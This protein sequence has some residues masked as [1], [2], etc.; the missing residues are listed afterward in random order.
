V[1]ALTSIG[2][3]VQQALLRESLA[4]HLEHG[5]NSERR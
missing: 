2:F 1:S 4:T 3:P 5:Q